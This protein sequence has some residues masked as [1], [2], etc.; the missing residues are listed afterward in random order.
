M[1]RQEADDLSDTL[2]LRDLDVQ[3]H[4]VDRLELEHHALGED[5]PST[6]R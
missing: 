1:P 6:T 2:Q 5:I 4:P 3:V